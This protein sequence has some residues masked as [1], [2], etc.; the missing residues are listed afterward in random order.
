MHMTAYLERKNIVLN[1][2]LPLKYVYCTF[3]LRVGPMSELLV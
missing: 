2:L 3:K 1:N